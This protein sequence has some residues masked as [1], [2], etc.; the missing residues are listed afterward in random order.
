VTDVEPRNGVRAEEDRHDDEDD[1][2][3]RDIGDRQTSKQERRHAVVAVE[4]EHHDRQQVGG[5]TQKTEGADEHRV[6]EEIEAG[7]RVAQPERRQHLIVIR[8]RRR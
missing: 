2:E 4:M 8:R 1:D 3:H 5:D 7:T 6:V